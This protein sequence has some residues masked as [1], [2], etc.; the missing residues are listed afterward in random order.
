MGDDDNTGYWQHFLRSDMNIVMRET[1]RHESY[2]HG[3]TPDGSEVRV[4]IG[5]IILSIEITEDQMRKSRERTADEA[6]ERVQG[7]RL[8]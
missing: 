1:G 8:T 3:V 6:K 7:L 5:E 4:L 2:L